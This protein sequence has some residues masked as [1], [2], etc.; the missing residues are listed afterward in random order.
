M[1]KYA[2]ASSAGQDI[3]F[4]YL[5][6]RMKE[7]RIS[8]KALAEIVGVSVGSMIRYFAKT[9]PMPLGVYFE[10]CGALELR[11]Y[12]IPSEN[13]TNQMMRQFFN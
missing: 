1:G 13:D 9:T 8:Q 2:Q 4:K 10:I 5:K 6:D 3:V 7:K 11:P 12:I